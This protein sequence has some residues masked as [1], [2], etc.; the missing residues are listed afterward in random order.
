MITRPIRPRLAEQGPHRLRQRHRLLRRNQIVENDIGTARIGPVL[1]GIAVAMLEIENGE[2][3]S[4]LRVILRW[5]V[6]N[7][8]AVLLQDGGAVG[9]RC[10][11]TVRGV[12]YKVVALDSPTEPALRGT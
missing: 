6:D 7:Q 2:A 12:G 8:L 5:G 9:V 4:R 10:D 1:L 11:R 3:P